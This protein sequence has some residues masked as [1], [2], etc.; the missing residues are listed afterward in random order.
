M[1]N[2]LFA[3]TLFLS[4]VLALAGTRQAPNAAD[5]PLTAHVVVSRNLPVR[6][7]SQELEAIIDGKQVVLFGNSMGVLALGDYKARIAS[8]SLVNPISQDV[9]LTYEFL[10]P[11][12]HKRTYILVGFGFED[13]LSPAP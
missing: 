9:S 13:R 3:L 6:S 12:G 10:L 1:R 11:N 4:P 7:N 8:G 5:Y 2:T